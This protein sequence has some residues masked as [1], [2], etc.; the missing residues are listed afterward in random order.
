M[1]LGKERMKEASLRKELSKARRPVSHQ[2]P[3]LDGFVISSLN[4]DRPRD[5]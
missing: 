4:D 3:E 2:N 5:V 1:D